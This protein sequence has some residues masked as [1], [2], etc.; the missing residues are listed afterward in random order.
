MRFDGQAVERRAHAQQILGYVHE[1]PCGGSGQP[2]VL[3]LTR[4]RG[5]GAGHHLAVDVWLH[6]A[7]VGLV[8]HVGRAVALV[9]GE[10]LLVVV[11]Q[12][13]GDGDP[14]VVVAE[15]AAVLFVS[16]RIGRD[17]AQ[18][19]AVGGV[20]GGEDGGAPIAGQ[21]V[22]HGLQRLLGL[23][24]VEAD[25]GHHA[26]AL[27]FDVDLAFGVFVGADLVR[28]GV[29]GAYEPFAVPAGG[30]DGFGDLADFRT[31]GGGLGGHFGVGHAG[32][33]SVVFDDVG[34]LAAVEHEHAADEH[35]FGNAGVVVLHGLEAFTRGVGEAVEVQAVVPIGAADQR[36]AVRS[37]VVDGEV[38]G[39]AQVF[40]QRL[41]GT[42]DV[43]ERHRFGQDRRVSGFGQVGVH[44]R[45]E[46]QR[47]VVEAAADVGV[48]LLGERL[49]LVPCG[50]VLQ[51]GG[52]DVDDAL[53]CAVRNQMHESQQ[54]LVGIAEA[55][56]AA[57]AGFV[58]GGGTGHVEGDHALVLMPDVHHAVEFLVS[59]LHAVGGQQVGPVVVEFGQRRLDLL[60]GGEAAEQLMRGLFVDDAHL[61]RIVRIL[62]LAVFADL[63]VA[64][65]EYERLGFARLQFHAYAVDRDREPAVRH[66][67]V[68]L[69]FGDDLRGVPAVELAEEF[70]TACVEACDGGV[71]GEERVMVA[72]FLELGLVVDQGG[73]VLLFDFDFA[74]GEVALEVGGVVHGVPQ[75]PFHGCGRV[76]DHGLVGGVGQVESVDFGVGLEWH[77]RGQLRFDAV[78][79]RFEYGVADA[80]T[81]LVGVERGLARQE[82][83]R[84]GVDRLGVDCVGVHQAQV[85]VARA[86]V[87]RNVVVTVT[88]DAAQ[89]CV[90]VEGVAAAGI[91]DQGEE[92]FV[93]EI[94]D[95]W[96][97]GCWGLDHVFAGGV[98]EMAVLHSWFLSTASLRLLTA[99]WRT[100]GGVA[101]GRGQYS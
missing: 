13:V 26:H 27:R 36:N 47:I 57:H 98:I 25:A 69:A 20:G 53:A 6:L 49:V 24:V 63:D 41:L 65:H 40:E 51:L 82:G 84:P 29:V 92:V 76:D 59:G 31:H 17:L 58:V 61:G 94:I 99:V 71:D 15:D 4:S 43:V 35:G 55:H 64:Q 101:R 83:G 96:Q 3:A 45:H 87:S 21:L 10:G 46:P 1:R 88:G 33:L 34:V 80:L 85:V 79:G 73:V 44:A 95:P 97:R 90:L 12:R 32:E 93:A 38:H 23:A 8:F 11:G 37:L 14:R 72:A 39:T 78:A 68:G 7:D 16:A 30:F 56:A 91:G 77:E 22:L 54:I 67:I 89:L 81:A 9:D 86:V 60:D 18:F 42:F 74:G 48:A 50:T 100:C 62:P 70:V 5:F 75:A 52:G 28:I 2:G 66:G 19:D